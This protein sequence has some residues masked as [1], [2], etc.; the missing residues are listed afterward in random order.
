MQP[1][2]HCGGYGTSVSH[3]L[4]DFDGSSFKHRAIFQLSNVSP[5]FMLA[6]VSAW[7]VASN[8]GRLEQRFLRVLGSG[9]HQVG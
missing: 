1:Q 3:D 8:D 6:M 5:N 4:D 9:Y 7:S 2:S